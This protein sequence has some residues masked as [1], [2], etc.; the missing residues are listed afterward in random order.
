MNG[1][2]KKDQGIGMK[3]FTEN[4]V[5]KE[6]VKWQ[7]FTPPIYN[8]WKQQ[9]KSNGVSHFGNSEQIGERIGWSREAVRNYFFL[10]N[11]IGTTILDFAIEHQTGRVPD[12]G[13]IVPTVNFTEGLLRNILP[14]G[15]DHQHELVSDLARRRKRLQGWLG[16][17]T[18]PL[19]TG[20][21]NFVKI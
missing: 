10:L 19:I 1:F 21:T 18:R 7:N 20:K 9:T 11:G 5:S 16:W 14:L 4:L 17:H 2:K 8:I 6:S 12:N 15:P 3:D 13:T